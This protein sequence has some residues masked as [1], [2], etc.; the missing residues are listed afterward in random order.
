MTLDDYDPYDIIVEDQRKDKGAR[1]AK[2]RDYMQRYIDAAIEHIRRNPSAP[3]T[4][5]DE[6]DVR[7]VKKMQERNKVFGTGGSINDYEFRGGIPMMDP[8]Q[9]AKMVRADEERRRE[10]KRSEPEKRLRWLFENLFKVK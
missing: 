1:A 6:A 2:G 9:H 10:M 8:F 4:A 7:D 3:H 5:L